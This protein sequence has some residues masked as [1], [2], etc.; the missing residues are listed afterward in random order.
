[1]SRLPEI[2]FLEEVGS[3]NDV[4]RELAEAGA[5]AG[6]AVVARRQTAGRGRR[7]H[8]WESPAG[9]LYLSVLLRPDVAP[10]R[11]P[12]LSAA[13]GLGTLDGLG[14]SNEA[15]LKWPNDLLARGRKLGGM[16]IEAEGGE[17][18]AA[19]AICGVGVNVESAPRGLGAISL[20]ELGR[21]PSFPELAG[22]LRDGIVARVDAWARV[23]AV[24]PL[25]G[26]REDY[27]SRLAWLGERVVVLSPTGGRL[28]DGTLEGVD[29]WGRAV[30]GGAAYASELVSLRPA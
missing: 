23:R 18:G 10:S 15:L 16:L 27:L 19:S 2:V 9:N 3:T 13:C 1:M 30:V 8:A 7:G 6:S 14:I 11:L 21:A 26:I 28:A 4:M 25:A 29:D 5:P 22:A 12:G 24:E 20:A 17:R